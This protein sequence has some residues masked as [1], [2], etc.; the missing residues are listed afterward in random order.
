MSRF[1][2][3]KKSINL[4]VQIKLIFCDSLLPC[5]FV[6][7]DARRMY[8]AAPPLRTHAASQ[9]IY[10]IYFFQCTEA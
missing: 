10:Q 8:K 9:G 7:T 4:G 5:L 2:F 1:L 3:E 6:P